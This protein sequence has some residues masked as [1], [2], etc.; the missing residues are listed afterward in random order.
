MLLKKVQSE[1]T[2]IVMK[3]IFSRSGFTLTEIIVSV[4]VSGMVI[5]GITLFMAKIQTDIA[6]T[7]LRSS[8]YLDLSRFLEK[9][10]EVRKSYSETILIDTGTGSYDA[11]IL[12]NASRTAGV[13]IGVI[14]STP[15]SPSE[16]KFDSVSNFETYGRKVLGVVPVSGA[17]ITA[18]GG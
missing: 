5:I 17:Q 14:D 11:I 10:H 2:K 13:A 7:T 3:S 4:A 15:G 8:V 12:T 9:I 16:N 18:L 6:T 1:V